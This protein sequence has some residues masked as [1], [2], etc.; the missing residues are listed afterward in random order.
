MIRFPKKIK[1]GGYTI[2]IKMVDEFKEEPELLGLFNQNRVTITLKQ[3][4]T[5]TEKRASQAICEN[6]IHE[7]IHA[8]DMIYN[9]TSLEEVTVYKLSKML[10]DVL[11]HNDLK[12]NCDEFPKYIDV[13]G[14]I[15][16]IKYPYV[17]EDTVE[18]FLYRF[19][20][21]SQELRLAK[22]YDN[23]SMSKQKTKSLLIKGIISSLLITNFFDDEE[24]EDSQL[25]SIS[26]GVYQFLKD[27]NINELARRCYDERIM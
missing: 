17:F 10:Y 22:E 3:Y 20:E 25:G 2:P 12:L 13:A 5:K 4:N 7:S 16:L 19:D 15:I 18:D 24:F 14:S 8:I 27:N 9:Q 23:I 21:E 11:V 6:L 26:E 1:I